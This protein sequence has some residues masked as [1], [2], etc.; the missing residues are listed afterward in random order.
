YYKDPVAT[1]EMWRGGWLHSGGVGSLDGGGYLFIVGRKK[2][3]IVRGGMNVYPHDVRGGLPPH[4]AARRAAII[5][6]PRPRLRP[7]PAGVRPPVLG[8]D[9]AAFVVIRDGVWVTADKLR[10]FAA[11]RLADYKV[12]RSI[13]FL[14][15]LPRN[16]TGK[17][18]KRRLAELVA[19]SG[20]A[21]QS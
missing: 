12:P 13:T 15:E 19:D 8:E 20:P 3:V 4:P 21:P 9:L 7:D 2:E 1:A 18:L 6:G 11:S 10:A 17:V 16:A 14:A 5:R